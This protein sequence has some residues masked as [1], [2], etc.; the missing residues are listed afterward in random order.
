MKF[1][2][3]TQPRHYVEFYPLQPIKVIEDAHF[4]YNLGQIFKYLVRAPY[5]NNELK[6][7]QKAKY[8]VAWLNLKEVKH[9]IN[10]NRAKKMI[11]EFF[12]SARNP[13]EATPLIFKE[14]FETVIKSQNP[15]QFQPYLDKL[16][17]QRILQLE[18]RVNF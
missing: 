7:L 1:D 14:A 18:S 9:L 6:D 17:E 16:I 10:S 15:E 2:E 8:Y 12:A 11:T 13:N 4:S 5:K 3:I